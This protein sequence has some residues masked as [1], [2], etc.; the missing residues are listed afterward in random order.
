MLCP[1]ALRHGCKR[2]QRSAGIISLD[3]ICPCVRVRPCSGTSVAV[4]VGARWCWILP[5]SQRERK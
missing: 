3:R 4:Q 5:L 2:L 1:K